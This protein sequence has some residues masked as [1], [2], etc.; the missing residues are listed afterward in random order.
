[1]TAQAHISSPSWPAKLFSQ[2]P[3]ARFGPDTIPPPASC[4]TTAPSEA[5]QDEARAPERER[6]Q[7]A[8]A[9]A[10]VGV[11]AEDANRFFNRLKQLEPELGPR[12]E[13][14][15][16]DFKGPDE[17]KAK[18]KRAAIKAE[19]ER[20]ATEFM[21]AKAHAFVEKMDK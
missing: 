19:I 21:G 8:A 18:A 10:S 20:I 9:A 6:D 4:T 13:Q 16:R 11:A 2:M 7:I 15:E 3:R 14:L 17:E 12:F 5:R 1:M